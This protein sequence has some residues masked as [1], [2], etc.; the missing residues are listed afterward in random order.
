MAKVLGYSRVKRI[1][2]NAGSVASGLTTLGRR[3]HHVA[4]A[5]YDGWL[6]DTP[7]SRQALAIWSAEKNKDRYI[8]RYRRLI[9]V[10]LAGPAADRKRQRRGKKARLP[11]S[12][13]D[14]EEALRIAT[15]LHGGNFWDGMMMVN[16]CEDE[17][18]ILVARHWPLIDRVA[19]ALWRRKSL[20]G[21]EFDRLVTP[22]GK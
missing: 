17:A 9:L 21:E 22:R 15:I 1:E 4:I 19:T 5:L 14:V 2:L 11:G 13:T 8:R 12:R 20:S 16:E 18:R 7:Q 10:L 3:K 6:T